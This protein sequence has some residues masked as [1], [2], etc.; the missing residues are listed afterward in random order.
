METKNLGKSI[1]IYICAIISILTIFSGN[2]SAIIAFPLIIIM[3][4]IGYLLVKKKYGKHPE[5]SVLISTND[6][7]LLYLCKIGGCYAIA[8]AISFVVA[9]LSSAEDV[10]PFCFFA[11]IVLFC[12]SPS[13]DDGVKR[14]QDKYRE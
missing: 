11:F 13:V 14:V 9:N 7:L 8:F 6:T 3:N 1:A 2:A 10:R 4:V 12:M 5:L